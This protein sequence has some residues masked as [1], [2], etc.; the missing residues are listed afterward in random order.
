MIKKKSNLHKDL[1]YHRI[2]DININIERKEVVVK[3]VSFETKNDCL[4]FKNGKLQSMTLWYFDDL[5]IKELLGKF[6]SNLEKEM[7][8][9]LYL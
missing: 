1:E 2:K 9:K 8:N 4:D 3:I 6:L 5:D 7:E